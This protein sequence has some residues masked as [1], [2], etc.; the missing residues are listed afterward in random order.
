MKKSEKADQPIKI[1]SIIIFSGCV[2]FIVVGFLNIA[3]NLY[4]NNAEY[5]QLIGYILFT[6]SAISLLPIANGIH[7]ITD[8]YFVDHITKIGKQTALWM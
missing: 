8:I 3:Y 7:A 6:L 1:H 2:L 5:F 4:F